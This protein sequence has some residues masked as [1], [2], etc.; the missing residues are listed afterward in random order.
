MCL[1]ACKP[2]R[3]GGVCV[4]ECVCVSAC[5]RM[6]VGVCVCACMWTREGEG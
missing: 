3:E 5:L 4:C 1:R 2:E 6:C